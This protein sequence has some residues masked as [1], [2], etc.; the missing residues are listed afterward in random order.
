MLS[1]DLN[2]YLNKKK[3]LK[4]QG[5]GSRVKVTEGLFA[6]DGCW[7]IQSSGSGGL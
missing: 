2:Q 5:A 6:G 7:D 3:A 1:F 4:I